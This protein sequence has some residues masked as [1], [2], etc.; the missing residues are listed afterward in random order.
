[1]MSLQQIESSNRDAQERAAVNNTR[2][3]IVSS[4]NI[5]TWKAGRGFPLPFPFIGDH[6]PEGYEP[7]GNALFVD[8]SGFSAKFPGSK[9]RYQGNWP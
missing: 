3:F 5:A 2:P 8:I 4:E 6:E 7:E 1:M 9:R